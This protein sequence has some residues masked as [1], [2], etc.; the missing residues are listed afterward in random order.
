[1]ARKRIRIAKIK[2]RDFEIHD[3]VEVLGQTQRVVG[4]EY[5]LSQAAVSKICQKVGRLSGQVVL[6]V[7]GETAHLAEQARPQRL[8]ALTRLHKRRLKMAYAQACDR[9]RE[10]QK[11]VM[12]AKQ[13]TKSTG[14]TVQETSSRTT[15]GNPRFLA[16]ALRYSECMLRFEGISLDGRVDQS[17]QGRLHEEPERTY[18]EVMREM[19]KQVDVALVQLARWEGKQKEEE[20]RSG[21]FGMR[22]EGKGE[23]PCA[24]RGLNGGTDW[25]SPSI[26]TQLP[27]AAVASASANEPQGREDQPG[28]EEEVSASVNGYQTVINETGKMTENQV[29]ESSEVVTEIQD[30]EPVIVAEMV[31]KTV[32]KRKEEVR[33]QKGE[34]RSQKGEGM[35]RDMQEPGSVAFTPSPQ[36]FGE[37][38]LSGGTG[39]PSGA[40]ETQLPATAVAS[41]KA[42]EPL[43]QERAGRMREESGGALLRVDPG[44]P[45]PSLP[46]SPSSSSVQRS[47][48]SVDS[49]GRLLFEGDGYHRPIPLNWIEPPKSKFPQ[50][51]VE[52]GY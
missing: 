5:G 4:L 24:E 28:R 36:S 50:Q 13:R 33:S 20:V 46:R 26:E 19:Q 1:M 39:W 3:K 47:K 44:S 10:S 21:E 34:G 23:E 52:E 35:A 17:G 29:L 6:P 8:Y 16:E 18:D 25:P 45:A 2:Q 9:W 37:R 51:W 40:N 49:L 7:G 32:I 30:I 48:V 41:A 14:E 42:H 43:P 12:T 22:S 11:N 31:E 15:P 27:A 38:G